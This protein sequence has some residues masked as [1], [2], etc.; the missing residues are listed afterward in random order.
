MSQ[1]SLTAQCPIAVI[2]NRNS[3]TNAR[4]AAAL[5]RA[6]EGLGSTRVRRYEFTADTSQRKATGENISAN[7]RRAIDEGA[8]AVIAAGG[9]GTAMAVAGA[10][11]GTQAAFSHLPLGTFNYFARGIGLPED[12]FDA[13]RAI[14]TGS[15]RPIHVGT[16]NGRVFLNNSSIGIYP[17]ILRERETIYAQFGR[18]RIMAHWSVAKTF[19]KFQ[20]PMHLTI[21]ADGDEIRCR[22]PL[23]F[24]FRSAYQLQSLGLE[25]TQSISDG[26]FAVL[27]GRGN[28]RADLFRTAARLI[29]RTAQLGRDYDLLTAKHLIVTPRTSRLLVAFDGERDHAKAPLEFKM[30]DVPLNVI[31]PP[32]TPQTKAA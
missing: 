6:I 1:P 22:S 20:R 31:M 23:L 19:W 16:V 30:S 18:R 29:T 13:G 10:V 21:N 26:Q 3:G 28:T 8:K 32:A 14:A 9:D 11:V 25:G 12:P 7:V 27:V 17:E 4:D 2:V 15:V 5:G 24:V